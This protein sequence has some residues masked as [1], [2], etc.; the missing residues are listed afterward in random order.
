[1]IRFGWTSAQVDEM[2]QADMAKMLFVMEMQHKVEEMENKK[3]GLQHR[4]PVRRRP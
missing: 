4:T 3:I 1:M 2:T